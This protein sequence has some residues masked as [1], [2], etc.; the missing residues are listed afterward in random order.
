MGKNN[1]LERQGKFFLI[2]VA[3][4]FILFFSGFTSAFD[5]ANGLTDYWGFD[6]N[7]GTTT[8]NGV[9]ISHNGNLLGGAGW[10]SSA[11]CII[12]NCSYVSLG[13]QKI[14]FTNIPSLHG[15]TAEY[16]INFWINYSS[17]SGTT[18]RI[19]AYNNQTALDGKQEIYIY[20]NPLTY[21][22][23][24][25][26]ATEQIVTGVNITNNSWTM[27]T[28][29]KNTTH[30]QMYVNGTLKYTGNQQGSTFS[31]SHWLVFNIHDG[32]DTLA[33]KYDEFGI[34]SRTLTSA[35]IT[36]LYN[37]GSGLAYPGASVFSISVNLT[38]P[39]N[40]YQTLN[41][42]ITFIANNTIAN[43]NFTNS[44]V[45]LW[46]SNGTL[47]NTNF[48]ALSGNISLETSLKI[49]NIPFG[50]YLWNYN[51]CG[52]NSSGENTTCFT[53]TSNFTLGI[54]P[55]TV[56]LESY[57]N[58]IYETDSEN[59][60][61]NITIVPAV[62]A[63]GAFLHYNGTAYAADHTCTSNYCV[64]NRKIDIPLLS[65]DNEYE[66]KSFFWQVT[67]FGSG[68]DSITQNSTERQQN[69]TNISL[70]NCGGSVTVRAVNF[71]ILNET[72]KTITP[73]DFKG[74]FYYYLGEGTVIESY[75]YSG[76]GS[77]NYGF[78][79]NHNVTFITN[80]EIKIQ[81]DTRIRNYFFNKEEYS[82]S[83]TLKNLFIPDSGS[84]NIIIRVRNQGLVPMSNILVNI[85]RFYPDEN[86]YHQVESRKTDEFGQF[87]SK[88][89]ENDA[90]YKFEFYDLGNNLLKTSD[91]I[92]VVCYSSACILDFIIEDTE[93]YFEQFQDLNLFTGSLLFSNVTNTFTFS[94]DDQRG[95]SVIIRL[96]VTRYTLNQS[97]V[98]CNDTSTL[99]L[100][101]LTCDVGSQSASYTAQ[102]FRI[103]KGEQKRIDI[104]NVK[105]GDTVSTYGVEGLLWAF[106]LLFTCVGIGAFNPTAG[107][108]FFGVGFIFCGLMGIISMPLP[109]FFAVT[110]ITVV[111]VWAVNT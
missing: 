103:L 14:N 47:F 26:G 79:I 31:P 63:I 110:A 24:S 89:L 100:S 3:L 73:A 44:T 57:N 30:I 42:N 21:N 70:I 20:S 48:T 50:S 95:E 104:L 55:Y 11:S 35:E 68:L 18:S 75:N 90:A 101:T 82:N 106:I 76:T 111:F 83:S 38:S 22:I 43:G 80:S 16:S 40:A 108:S 28:F 102:V 105:V 46:Y 60:E 98:I 49:F 88:L 17:A 7:T 4:L 109:V 66:N 39:S 41:Q 91:K 29:A 59:F 94:W 1:R 12:G 54:N 32:T 93:D 34:W 62:S 6:E 19:I 56:N 107:A 71:T 84:T 53:G 15:I 25:H 74:T 77:S 13:D 51:T 97:S 37:S 61:I 85:S 67:F 69:V 81:N 36:E 8:V 86:Q 2:G 65:S 5:W 96:E 64:I 58:S 92:T 99:K 87:I 45:Y 9:N 27:L 23:G 78:C 72:T 52:I 33:A 10:N